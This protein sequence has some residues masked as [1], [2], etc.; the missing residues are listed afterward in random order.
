MRVELEIERAGPKLAWIFL[1][2]SAGRAQPALKTMLVGPDSL[3]KAKKFRAG[4]AGPYWVGPYWAG[5]N[6][7]QF[8]LG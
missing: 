3:L 1:K 2:R 8:F 4:R 7:A 5:P 6:L